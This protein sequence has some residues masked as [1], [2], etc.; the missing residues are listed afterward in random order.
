[1]IDVVRRFI[2]D[3]LMESAPVSGPFWR[4]QSKGKSIFG[5]SSGLATKDRRQDGIFAFTSP[6]QLFSTYTWIRV[7]KQPDRY[8]MVKFDGIVTGRPDDSEGVVVQPRR[9]LERMPLNVWL[10]DRQP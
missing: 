2:R 8:E 5:H 9:I 1:M 3:V 6:D 4:V 10:L 7:K